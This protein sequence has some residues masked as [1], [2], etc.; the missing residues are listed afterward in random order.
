VSLSAGP[1]RAADVRDAIKRALPATVSVEERD[2][3]GAAANELTMATGAIVSADGLVV[4]TLPQ[5]KGDKFHVTLSDGREFD[6]RLLVDDHRTGMKLL[7][8]DGGSLPFLTAAEE[9]A[10]IGEDVAATYCLD[11]KER[12]A[13]RGIVAAV[14]REV[15]NVGNDLLQID[16]NVG[17][18]SAGSPVV[19]DEA[20]LRGIVVS[21]QTGTAHATT[22]ALP[23]SRLVAL[24]QARSG[25]TPKVIRRGFLGVTVDGAEDSEPKKPVIAHPIEGGAA[26]AAGLREGDQIIA[27]DDAKIQRPVDLT[28]DLSRRAAGDK[29]RLTVRRDSKD[30]AFN[31]VLA[32]AEQATVT[33]Q[34]GPNGNVLSGNVNWNTVNPGFV[35]LTE[36]DGTLKAINSSVQFL[37]VQSP[38]ITQ[39][40]QFILDVTTQKS[41]A[42]TSEELHVSTPAIRVERSDMEKKLEQIGRDVLTLRQQMESLTDEMRRLQKELAND[43]AHRAGK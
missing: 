41:P 43:A 31:I 35:Y 40:G 19:D 24:L 37:A 28:R 32:P 6:A 9:R 30:Q 21:R 5:A 23:A 14:D 26:K 8:I 33:A 42:K 34:S 20:K 15:A 39:N 2:K 7:K 38:P 1:L 16:I 11:L 29:V 3:S 22:F 12:A 27:L 4:T 36:K 10:P 17:S 25:D 13:A 18:M